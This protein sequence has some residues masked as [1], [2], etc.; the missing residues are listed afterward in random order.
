M[1]KQWVAAGIAAV[2]AL[3]LASAS[4]PA[5]S[6]PAPAATAVLFD[7][8]HLSN[9]SAG[10]SV[11]YKFERK[12]S[13]TKLLG[14]NFT[15]SV[16]VAVTAVEDGGTRAVAVGVF[17]GER[18]RPEQKITGMTGN[19]VLVV[20]LDRA[21]TNFAML[22]GGKRPYLKNRFKQ[23]LG[24]GAKVE[25]VTVTYK[26]QQLDGF[27]VT[28]A[29]YVGDANALKMQGYDG[30]TFEIVVSDKVPGHFVA[31]RAF[32]SAPTG[33]SPQLEEK[34]MLEGVGEIK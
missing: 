18:A 12:A 24:Q 9:M 2:A 11:V 14:E 23:Q 28:V 1:S 3:G 30:S 19:P 8:S 31:T 13:D 16:K 20:F 32:Y 10:D 7:A 6:A 15:D 34:M 4:P 25:P 22:A 17:S 27:K 21:V 26:G 5:I 29:P 33:D